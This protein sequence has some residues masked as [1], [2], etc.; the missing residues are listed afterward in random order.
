MTTKREKD[1]F[2]DFYMSP[3]NTIPFEERV[4]RQNSVKLE[5]T[6]KNTT[7]KKTPLVSIATP[8]DKPSRR[9]TS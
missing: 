2:E 3:I 8:Y 7:V 1:I 9:H 6:R 5:V 4:G